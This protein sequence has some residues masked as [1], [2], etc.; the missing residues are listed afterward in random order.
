MKTKERL[1][2]A[3]LLSYMATVRQYFL[4]R[5]LFLLL[6]LYRAWLWHSERF[7]NLTSTHLRY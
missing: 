6:I 2:L 5:Y 1:R 4:K 7:R 3:P